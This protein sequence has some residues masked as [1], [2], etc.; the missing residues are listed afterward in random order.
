MEQNQEIY[1]LPLGA[2]MRPNAKVLPEAEGRVYVV[3]RTKP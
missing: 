1:V 2:G 3:E